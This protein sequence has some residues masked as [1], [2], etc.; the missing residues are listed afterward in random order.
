[1]YKLN[2]QLYIFGDESLCS[3]SSPYTDKILGFSSCAFKG[4][5]GIK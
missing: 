3:Y 5:R 1:M 4:E 2:V